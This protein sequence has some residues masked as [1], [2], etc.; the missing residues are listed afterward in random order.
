MSITLADFYTM[1]SD[2][3]RRGTTLDSLI[4]SKVRQAVKWIEDLHTFKHMEVFDTPAIVTRGLSIPSGY[5]SMEFWR[6]VKDDG[7]GYRYLTLVSP[8][9]VSKTTTDIPAAYWESADNYFYMDNTP[10]KSY[11]SE[12]SYIANTVLPTDTS[13]S[14]F[15]INAFEA[16][17]LHQTCVMFGPRM[18]DQAFA[19][20]HLQR[21]EE[22]MKA[23]IDSD[24]ERRQANEDANVRYGHEFIEQINA[25]NTNFT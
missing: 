16:L 18:R 24:V 1:V 23:A 14:P 19:A 22:L 2:E 15:F 3:L 21:R 17:T 10:D 5:K 9:D 7:E 8:K 12:R 6:I 4:P 25:N 11:A 13:Q 20:A